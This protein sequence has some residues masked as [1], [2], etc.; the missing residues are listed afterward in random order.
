MKYATSKREKTSICNL[1]RKEKDLSWDHI[2]PK[3]GIEVS[4]VK[5]ETIFSLMTGDREK[6][7]T[8]ESQNGMK[9]RTICSECN[10]FL[11][12]EFDPIINDFAN[13][14]GRYLV[15]SL[16]LPETISHPVKPQ[17]LIK[18]I[19]GH[20]VA[21]KVEVENTVFDQQAR[22]YV[23]DVDATLPEDI[24][25]F[26][27]IYPYDCSTTI[28][29]FGMFTPRGTFQEAAI[30]QTMK[31]FPIAYLCCDKPEYADLENLSQYREA[32]LDEEIEIPINLQ[33]VE[34]PYWPEAP[35][36]DPKNVFFGGRSA[37]NAVHAKPKSD[38]SPKF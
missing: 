23:L 24:N 20:L 3:G 15:S 34:H 9:Y 32:G 12:A 31:Y 25:V 27:W 22:E 38:R 37:S 19:L 5:M 4:P 16:E 14:V 17:R 26:Y 10:S 30:F 2:P 1:C 7:K 21:A 13:D 29:D 33:R 11:G 36:D 28:R 6:P 8:R 18:A 35:S